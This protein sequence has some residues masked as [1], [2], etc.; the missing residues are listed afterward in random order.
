MNLDRSPQHDAEHARGR[1]GRGR[2]RDRDGELIRQRSRQ[3]R[4]RSTTSR[5]ARRPRSRRPGSGRRSPSPRPPASLGVLVAQGPSRVRLALVRRS[6]AGDPGVEATRQ[7]R[8]ARRLRS[9]RRGLLGAENCLVGAALLSA[10]PAAAQAQSSNSGRYAA[11]YDGSEHRCAGCLPSAVALHVH[12]GPGRKGRTL[13]RI[14]HPDRIRRGVYRRG[15][16]RW[17]V[18]SRTRS[19]GRGALAGN[20]VGASGDVSL[21]L[22]AG[23]NVLIGGSRRS[24]DAAAGFAGRPGRGQSRGGNRGPHASGS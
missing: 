6:N 9:R 19:L 11:M 23:G 18:V 13:F 16:M 7:C 4:S 3:R 22:G 15:V 24:V 20:Y 10:D 17:R 5:K 1:R 14:D 8:L 2:S 12:P 21:G